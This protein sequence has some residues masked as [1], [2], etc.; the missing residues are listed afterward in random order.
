MEQA[1]YARFLGTPADNELLHYYDSVA[2]MVHFPTEESFGMVVLEGLGRDLKFFGAQLGGIVDI[3][4]DL[5]GAELFAPR[6]LARVDGRHRPLDCRRT[7][8]GPRAQPP[9]SGN[10][11]IPKP[12]RGGTWKFTGICSISP[13]ETVRVVE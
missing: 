4:Q 11:M 6:R 5:P 10:V 13:P 8:R 9:S 12:S 1:G 2:A 3:V 7:S